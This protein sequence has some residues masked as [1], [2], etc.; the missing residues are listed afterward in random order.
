MKRLRIVRRSAAGST[1]PARPA[2]LVRRLIGGVCAAVVGL[3][4]VAAG[5]TPAFADTI[6]DQQWYLSA[7]DVAAAQAAGNGGAGVTVAVIDS[8]VDATHP[9]LTGNVVK[10]I[11]ASTDSGDGQQDAANHGTGVAAIIAGHG[12]GPGND[13]G[14]LGIAPK[15]KILPISLEGNDPRNRFDPDKVA[16]AI[17]LAVQRG[18]KV[19]SAAFGTSTT[20]AVAAAVNRALD[21]D[22]VIVAAIP[23]ASGNGL[24]IIDAPAFFPGVMAVCSVDRKGNHASF[25]IPGEP[26]TAPLTLCAPGVDG[27]SADPGG[28]YE[29]G[30]FGTSMSCAIVA[31]A[32]ALIRAKYPSL[33]AY[34]VVHRMTATAVDKGDPGPDKLYGWGNLNLTAALSA[35]IAPTTSP[36]PWTSRSATPTAAPVSPDPAVA[37]P[38]RSSEGGGPSPGQLVAVAG[39]G[40]VVLLLIMLLV[41]LRIRRTRGGPVGG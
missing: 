39:G 13:D 38:P 31:G 17:D 10:G 41:T 35:D 5:G 18:A 27:V 4:P 30:R 28:T 12:H 22:V 40:L 9:D 2:G 26:P 34:E 7:M 16:H 6:R 25:S 29:T 1:G 11:N 3:V 19:I 33:P 8:G 36:T 21:A 14:V 15:A 37:A 20:N 24:D 32:A 23:N